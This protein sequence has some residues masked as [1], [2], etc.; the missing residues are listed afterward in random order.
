V[1]DLLI[2][3]PARP[4]HRRSPRKIRGFH[5]GQERPCLPAA[6]PAEARQIRWTVPRDA[7]S[8][9]RD[10][11]G[12]HRDDTPRARSGSPAPDSSLAVLILEDDGVATIAPSL[13]LS[14]GGARLL[15]DPLRRV[16]GS[17]GLRGPALLLARGE[18]DR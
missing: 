4:D 2:L 14:S 17:A 15:L 8:S 12:R 13:G 7:A 11:R 3:P 1:V 6:T 16:S 18:R 9:G 5:G 10:C